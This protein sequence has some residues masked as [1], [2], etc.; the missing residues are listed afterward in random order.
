MADD[1]VRKK[2]GPAKY[3]DP[4]NPTAETT[5]RVSLERLRLWN[6]LHD[7]IRQH[8][9][10]VVSVPGHKE[11]R[12]EIPKDSPLPAKL[13]ELGYQ[14]H[15]HCATTRITAGTSQPSMSSKSRCRGN[16]RNNCQ[17]FGLKSQ[18]RARSVV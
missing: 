16:D 18:D 12:I 10:A 14:P 9:G 2:Y 1:P 7:Y 5:P 11:L 15:H 3:S 17:D 13:V 6:A 4:L 8:G